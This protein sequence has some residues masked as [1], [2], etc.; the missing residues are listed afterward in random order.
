MRALLFSDIH[1]EFEGNRRYRGSEPWEWLEAQRK[2][3]S[4]HP[5]IGPLLSAFKGTLDVVLAAGD[6]HTGTVGVKWLGMV[7]AY[8]GVPV[9]YVAGNH[10]FYGHERDDVRKSLAARAS[11]TPG[12]HFLDNTRYNLT[13]SNGQKVAILGSTLWT[14][15]RGNAM[16]RRE[17]DDNMLIAKNSMSDFQSIYNGGR[18]ATPEDTIEWHETAVAW[19]G[20]AIEKARLDSDKVLVMTHHAPLL[21]CAWGTSKEHLDFA[22]AS[23][24]SALVSRVDSWVHGHI[25]DAGVRLFD[26]RIPVIACCRG[27]V[28]AMEGWDFQP[29]VTEL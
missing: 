7:A 20:K 18:P 6:I 21:E 27:Y 2:A 9:L 3:E 23:D 17:I 28:S 19:L 15:M 13:C 1:L 4:G 8:L 12:V 26:A 22:Y 11:I 24:L 5:E 14:D 25:H 16:A 29:G 10:E